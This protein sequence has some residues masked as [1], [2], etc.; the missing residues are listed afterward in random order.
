MAD[1]TASPPT[2]IQKPSTRLFSNPVT[3]KELRSRMRGRRA[4][5]V[6]TLYLVILAA[7]LLFVYL[8]Y[9]SSAGLPSS[10]MARSAGKG[11]FAAIL[12]VQVILVA[13]IGPAFTAAAIS[14]ERER[15]TFDLLRTTLLSAES[16][17]LGKLFS[18]LS[19]ILLLV[20][21][22]IPLQSLAF[23]LGGLSA[24]EL[25]LSQVL[26]LIAAVTYALY[27]LW[28]SA[29]M[30]STLTATVATFAGTLFLT[31]GIPL[32]AFIGLFFFSTLN[33]PSTILTSP[34]PT[35]E[36]ILTYLGL[37]LAAMNLPAALIVSE[38]FLLSEDTLLGYTHFVGTQPIW[39][40][41][42]WMLFIILHLTAAVLLYVA[43]VRRVGR[44]S[45]V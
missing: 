14:G 1:T 13:F 16:F 4:F 40:F 17:V 29:A 37:V 38:A 23:L 45:E 10:S 27:G 42:P 30:R 3:M 15:Q 44:V 24:V 12:G 21:V 6:L 31:F 33:V 18:S 25:V 7:A 22:S 5:A 8:I 9:L 32:L 2:E 43:A 26:V 20:A 39:I 11:I 19:Y 41:S 35:F 36:I 34:D 28:C